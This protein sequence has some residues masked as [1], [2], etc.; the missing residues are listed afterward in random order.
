MA[1]W[2]SVEFA[3]T[4]SKSW[5]AQ[6]FLSIA[7]DLLVV[8]DFIACAVAGEG[9]LALYARCSSAQTLDVSVSGPFRH[10]ILFGSLITAL[11]L[12][13]HARSLNQRLHSLWHSVLSAEQRCVLAFSVLITVGYATRASDDLARLWLLSWFGLFALAVATT[14]LACGLY[15]DRL[16]GRGDLRESVAIVGANRTVRDRLAARIGAEADV[17]GTYCASPHPARP[18]G[19]PARRGNLTDLLELGRCGRVDSIIL[20]VEHGR[21]ADIGPI[22]DQLKALPVQVA[23]CP[24]ES[25]SSTAVPQMRILGGLPMAVVADR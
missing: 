14:R 1:D 13:D 10:D 23:V 17:V 2:S 22:I 4:A 24:D 8:W 25:W 19:S 21:E 18:S 12:R 9:A 20:A 3:G 7:G 16:H 15:L 11:I 5:K 6:D